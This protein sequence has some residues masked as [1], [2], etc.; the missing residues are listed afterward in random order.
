MRRQSGAADGVGGDVGGRSEEWTAGLRESLVPACLVLGLLYAVFAPLHLTLL[1]GRPGAVLGVVAGMSTVTLLAAAVALRRTTLPLGWVH[2]VAVA[3]TAVAAGN[4]LLHLEITDE[5]RQSSNLM[6]LMVGVGAVFL[7]TRWALATGVAIL[8]GWT[9]TVWPTPVDGEVVHYGAGLAS[10]TGLAVLV[11]IAR[12]RAV[13]RLIMA[14]SAAEHLAV[15]D[16]LTGS[17]NRRGFMLLAGQ[18]L[19]EARRR[20]LPVSVL[21]CDVDGL[22]QVNDT[23]GHPAGDRLLAAVGRALAEVCR[24]SDV[25]ARWGGDEFCIV[26]LGQGPSA[27]ELHSRLSDQLGSAEQL[28]LS[29]PAGVS[30]GEAT[31][32][33]GDVSDAT[34]LV[35]A[36]DLDMYARRARARDLGR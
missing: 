21:F 2:P 34:G 36:A 20:E 32:D 16:E 22:K 13:D 19:R 18:V 12:R 10:A 28:G 26:T 8:L 35:A 24:G 29:G 1:G 33:A 9:A 4:G 17:H 5:V 23:W 14:R 15:T 11:N 3:V 25:V 31:L 27:R 30:V 6:L 7:N